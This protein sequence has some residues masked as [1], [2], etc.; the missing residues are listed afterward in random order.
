[1]NEKTRQMIFAMFSASPRSGEVNADAYLAMV[2]L[3]CQGAGDDA[4]CE[5]VVDAAMGK[6]EGQQPG[7]AIGYDIFAAHARKL[8]ERNELVRQRLARPAL[9]APPQDPA[10]DFKKEG[11]EAERAARVAAILSKYRYSPRDR[12][13]SDEEFREQQKRVVAQANAEIEGGKL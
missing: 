4:I 6:I 2:E 7:W 1:M 13:Q 9:P 11:T 8:H 12:V 3:G 5:A 10:P